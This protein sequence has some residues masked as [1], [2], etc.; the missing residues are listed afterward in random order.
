MK[1]QLSESSDTA[2]LQNISRSLDLILEGEKLPRSEINEMNEDE[3]LDI[4]LW[5]YQVHFQ[6]NVYINIIKIYLPMY[7]GFILLLHSSKE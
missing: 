4:L 2:V 1:I 7:L 6:N 5:L 3:I